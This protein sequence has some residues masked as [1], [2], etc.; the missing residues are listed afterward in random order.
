MKGKAAL[1]FVVKVLMGVA[2]VVSW[3]APAAAL[4]AS[5]L[6]SI[7]AGTAGSFSFASDVRLNVR[8]KAAEKILAAERAAFLLRYAVFPDR[9]F[10]ASFRQWRGEL[11]A[12]RIYKSL[13]KMP[14]GGLLHIHA[15]AVGAAAW[16]VD[17]AFTEPGCFIYWGPKSDSYALGQLAVFPGGQVPEGWV[18]ARDLARTRP[19]LRSELLK[20]YTLGPEDAACENI[21]DE[22]EAIFQRVD[23]FISYRPVFVAY[24]RQALLDMAKD[25]VQ[26]VELRTGIDPVLGED[27]GSIQDENVIDLYREILAGVRARY[28]EFDLRII[29][30][31]WRVATLDEAAAG[32]T[33]ARAFTAY[34]PDLVHGFDFEGEEDQRKSYAYYAEVLSSEPRLPLYLHAGESL[35]ASNTNVRDALDLGALRIGHGINLGFFPGI[36]DD[37]RRAGVTMEVCPISN[38]ALRYVPDVRAHPA[39][40]WLQRGLQAVLASDDPGIF[41]SVGMT[42]DIAQAYLAWNLDLRSLKK[43]A[44]NSITAS[45]LSE[46][47]VRRQ[48]Q[49]FELR[50]RRWINRILAERAALDAAAAPDAPDLADAA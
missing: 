6:C 39:K 8:E 30:A 3:G 50:W 10:T 22:F 41:G 13:R 49:I 34:A 31:A 42:D 1:Q 28:P 48:L 23:G 19:N 18:P 44:L 16:I 43:L 37:L 24:Y 46:D 5:P 36:E 17:R 27:G 26:F 29:Y 25:G 12:S 9:P 32:L 4:D 15:S 7:D 45:T 14:K 40:G 35:S 2:L 21:W 11:R 38:Q 20:L 33:R 47:R